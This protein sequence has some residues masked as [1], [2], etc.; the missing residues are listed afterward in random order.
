ML[1]I[2]RIDPQHATDALA[3]ILVKV[4]GLG[5]H[6][7]PERLFS[8]NPGSL[9]EEPDLPSGILILPFHPQNRSPHRPLARRNSKFDKSPYD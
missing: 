3:T 1:G 5:T 2:Q 8:S 4:N 7:C 6:W 9:R